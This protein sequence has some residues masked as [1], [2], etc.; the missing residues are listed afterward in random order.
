M[1]YLIAKKLVY[2]EKGENSSYDHIL[3]PRIGMDNHYTQER[4]HRGSRVCTCYPRL[5][6]IISVK[7]TDRLRQII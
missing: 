6:L 4:A 1:G 2:L 7:K 3:Y 5:N